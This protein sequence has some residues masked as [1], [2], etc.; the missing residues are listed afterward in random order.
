[1]KPAAATSSVSPFRSRRRSRV[2][3]TALA[4]LLFAALL[5]SCGN[6]YVEQADFLRESEEIGA[7]TENPGVLLSP[8]IITATEGGTTGSY[9]VSL[10]G[11]PAAEVT[12]AVNPGAQ[13]ST[14]TATL[15]FG[16]TDWS[17]PQ[18]VTVTAVDDAAEEGNHSD[19]ISH[20]TSSDDPGYEGLDGGS[21]TVSIVD[22]D[23]PG[24]SVSTASVEVTEGGVGASYE[25][26]LTTQPTANVTITATPNLSEVSATPTSLIFNATTWDAPQQI[27]VDAVDDAV[28]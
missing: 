25:I 28:F 2:P 27:I 21:V 19:T 15:L 8:T 1:M 24:V 17:I 11:A 5:G 23:A 18:Q 4:L 20:T 26:V 3:A 14:S 10:T 22:N 16:P 7:G 6:L 9:E 12:V 13:L